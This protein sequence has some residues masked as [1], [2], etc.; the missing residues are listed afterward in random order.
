MAEELHDNHDWAD[1]LRSWEKGEEGPQPTG[2]VWSRLEDSLPDPPPKRRRWPFVLLMLLCGLVGGVLISR[3]PVSPVEKEAVSTVKEEISPK[4]SDLVGAVG[5][6]EPLRSAAADLGNT[7]ILSA[8]STPE[9]MAIPASGEVLKKELRAVEASIERSS[10]TVSPI[11]GGMLRSAVNNRVYRFPTTVTGYWSGPSGGVEVEDAI[12]KTDSFRLVPPQIVPLPLR[13]IFPTL[14]SAGLRLPYVIR[15]REKVRFYV[16]GG[17]NLS[18]PRI[19]GGLPQRNIDAIQQVDGLA[20]GVYFEGRLA[21]KRHLGVQLGISQIKESAITTYR[22]QRFYDP[23][24]EET[25]DEGNAVNKYDLTIDGQYSKA[26]TELEIQRT[27]NQAFN[28]RIGIRIQARLEESVQ[29]IQLPLTFTYDIPLAPRLN[30]R[31]GGGLAWNRQ[32]V[33]AALGVQLSTVARLRVGRTRI[34]NRENILKEDFWTGRV[35]AGVIYRPGPRWEF[36]AM[37]AWS[38]GLGQIANGP[39]DGASYQR[40][41][42]RMGVLRNF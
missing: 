30:F 24:E 21:W 7:E 38:Y 5:E 25:D 12:G 17:I 20:S 23:N 27:D 42:V 9:F 14:L 29:L 11:P 26:D 13:A 32:T 8:R 1:R 10:P 6:G 18:A 22:I 28:Q 36:G 37:G 2:D 31:G 40:F 35:A 41:G 34:I 4:S 39:Q 16:G 19:E 15:P 3:W 33:T